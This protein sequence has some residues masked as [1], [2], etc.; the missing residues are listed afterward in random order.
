MTNNDLT[1]IRGD[2]LELAITFKDDA[3]LPVDLTDSTVF[4]TIKRRFSDTDDEA[5][6]AVEI[7]THTDPDNG[8]TTLS[9]SHTD[10]EDLDITS[11]DYPYKWDLQ[12][13][14]SSGRITSTKAGD[15]YVLPDVTN[16]IT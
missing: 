5:L 6:L 14:D 4:F 1:I 8:V 2:D 13:K 15:C 9:I 7:T 3:G 16:R 11:E 12:L 10:T